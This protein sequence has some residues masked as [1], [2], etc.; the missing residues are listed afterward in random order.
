MNNGDDIITYFETLIDDSPDPTYEK[1]LLN[2]VKNMIE[3]SRDWN[4]L[5]AFDNSKTATP[6]DTYLT[7]KA[8]PTDFGYARRIFLNGELTPYVLIGL[9]ERDRYKDVYKRWYI[10][11]A[12][13]NFFLCGKVS[14]N[15]AINMY[16]TKFTPDVKI[17][18][19]D[20]LTTAPTW[21]TRY[22]PLI[23]IKMAEE[24]MAAADIDDVN[25]RLSQQNLRLAN[26]M[27]KEMIHWDARQKTLE[28]NDKMNGS[29]DFDTYP[30]IIVG[31]R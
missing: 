16:Y 17:T 5:R 24:H 26:D 22:L 27:L 15:F 20:A 23:A 18:T 7:A 29:V 4:F 28:Y 14:Q 3:G 6:A 1:I 19:V 25:F 9:E 12:N 2:K 8:L 10:D 21:P 30:N 31:P 13:N 11:F